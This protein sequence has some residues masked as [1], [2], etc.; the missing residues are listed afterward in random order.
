MWADY[1][2]NHCGCDAT[3]EKFREQ[4]DGKTRQG[5]VHYLKRSCVS[6][7]SGF[8]PFKELSRKLKNRNLVLAEMFHLIVR[9]EARPAG[10]FN[11]PMEDFNRTLDL[12][13]FTKARSDTF[14]PIDWIIYTVAR[15]FSAACITALT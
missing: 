14:F 6:E 5:S 12:G 15:S 4:I 3:F 9:D 2:L 11:K 8:L 1:N 10:F 13:Y 7:S